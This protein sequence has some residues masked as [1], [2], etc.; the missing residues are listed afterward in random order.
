MSESLN[1]GKTENYE[2]RVKGG[3]ATVSSEADRQREI[4]NLSMRLR[5]LYAKPQA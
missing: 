2:A 4:W 1:I 3:L 5:D